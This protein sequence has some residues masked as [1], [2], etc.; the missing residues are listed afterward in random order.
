MK[1]YRFDTFIAQKAERDQKKVSEISKELREFIGITPQ[2]FSKL[3]NTKYSKGLRISGHLLKLSYCLGVKMDD[4][5]N[6]A[7]KEQ[8]LAK[9]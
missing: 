5:I 7:I 2:A 4:L 1:A 6:P 9:A 8:V 3:R